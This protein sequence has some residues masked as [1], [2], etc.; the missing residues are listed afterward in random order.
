MAKQRRQRGWQEVRGWYDKIVGDQGHYYHRQVVL[1]GVLKLLKLDKTKSPALLDLAC[2]Q[3][4]LSRAIPDHVEYVG[5]DASESLV[6]AAE[7]RSPSPKQQFAVGDVTESL[8]V[9]RKDFTHAT[10]ILALQ[11]IDD[12]ASALKRAAEHLVDGGRL[13]FVLNHPCFRIPRQS[14]WGVDDKAKLQYRRMNRYLSPLEI[15][16]QMQP[17]KGE[18]SVTT[19]SYHNSLATYMGWLKDAGFVVE[20]MEEWCSDKESTGG[21]AKMENRARREFPLFLA[22]VAVKRG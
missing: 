19:T 5:V 14:A 7:R 20:D 8:P 4:I 3:G 2:G 18:K 22:V 1:P 12:G 15:P 21:A 6:T 10:I 17:G 11:N 13:V 16:I 9:Q